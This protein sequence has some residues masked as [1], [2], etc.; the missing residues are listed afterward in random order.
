VTD[1]AA[2]PA[3]ILVVDDEPRYVR[4]ITLALQGSGYRVLSAGDGPAALELTALETPDLIL[5][6]VGLPGLDG[7]EVCRRIRAFSTV[8]IIMLTARA[9]EADKVA[10]LDA[11]ADDYLGKPFGPPELLAR[12]RAAL[13]RARYADAPSSE[14]VFQHDDL[15]ID[16]ARCEV[17]RGDDVV[18]LTP[19]EYRV[20]VHLARQAGRVILPA[21][22]LAAV[23]GPEYRDETQ[24][25]RLYISRLRRKIETDPDHP[26][27][28]LTKPGIGYLFA[29]P[30]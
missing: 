29:S 28:I 12:V 5:L 25:V 1:T 30:D 14:P 4:W 7:L 22:L 19:T 18:P 9:A 2:T 16:H 3:K 17:R 24:H 8:P 20:L 13:R 6:D 26:R 23:W 11:G 10:G 15:Q 21:E 27:H